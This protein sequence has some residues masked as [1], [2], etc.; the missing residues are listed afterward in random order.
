MS[1][2]QKNPSKFSKMDTTFPVNK[3]MIQY[4]RVVPS[5]IS[6]V[7]S[8]IEELTLAERPVVELVIITVRSFLPKQFVVCDLVCK[9]NNI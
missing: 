5:E 4:A 3:D 1:R 9:Y 2:I 7:I 6:M 8:L